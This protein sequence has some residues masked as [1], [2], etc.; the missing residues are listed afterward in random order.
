MKLKGLLMKL[1]KLNNYKFIFI[2][3]FIIL[4]SFF[5]LKA[6]ACSNINFEKKDIF[7]VSKYNNKK[8]RFNVEIA[9][10][11]LK[12]KIGLQC[13]TKM[14]LNEGMFFIWETEDFRSFWMKNTSIPLD[15]IFLDK[16]YKIVDIYF[17]AKPFSLIPILNKKKAKY[18]LELNEGVFNSY[19]FNLKDKIIINK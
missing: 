12:K 16:T 19:K 9:D 6:S 7:I 18:V 1:K 10:T 11:D 15:I 4:V 2:I 8:I 17:N 13:K 5:T 14:E 3:N